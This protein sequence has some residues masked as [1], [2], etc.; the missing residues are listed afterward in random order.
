MHL[1]RSFSPFC[2]R[3]DLTFCLANKQPFSSWPVKFFLYF[4]GLIFHSSSPDL[5]TDLCGDHVVFVRV[6]FGQTAAAITFPTCQTSRLNG[7]G[8]LRA[9][10][11]LSGFYFIS[12][13]RVE[14]ARCDHFLHFTQ[15]AHS[16]H[17]SAG[18]Y[19]RQVNDR[20]R[21]MAHS[22]WTNSS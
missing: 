18:F 15:F 17:C 20:Q 6:Q 3:L 16:F 19:K 8:F 9:P 10:A 13:V 11:L 14:T 1:L 2:T 4:W 21:L 7:H 12:Y 5:S 22:D